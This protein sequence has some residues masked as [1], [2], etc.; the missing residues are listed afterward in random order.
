ML[1]YI[2]FFSSPE[3]SLKQITITAKYMHFLQLC[4]AVEGNGDKG[5][6]MGL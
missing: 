4:E 2:N 3:Y 6:M 1:S 5:G